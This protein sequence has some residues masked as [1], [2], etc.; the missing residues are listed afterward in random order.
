MRK[1]DDELDI[2]ISICVNK[3]YTLYHVAYCPPHDKFCCFRY[4]LHF[5][6][7]IG[8]FGSAE[9]HSFEIWL[10]DKKFI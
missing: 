4:S 3:G 5:F 8:N 7:I 6:E 2:V 10:A 9:L 1:P